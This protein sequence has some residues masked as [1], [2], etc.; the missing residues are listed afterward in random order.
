MR[1]FKRF[2]FR[3]LAPGLL[4]VLDSR[5][6]G[7]LVATINLFDRLIKV[8]VDDERLL[9]FLTGHSGLQGFRI[10]IDVRRV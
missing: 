4:G 8:Y 2:E 10:E 5:R 6:G 3:P 7:R 9:N 1:R